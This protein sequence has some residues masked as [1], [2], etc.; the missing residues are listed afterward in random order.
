M[1]AWIHTFIM[2]SKMIFSY[3]FLSLHIKYPSPF[4]HHT[5]LGLCGFSGCCINGLSNLAEMAT[6]DCPDVH[7]CPVLLSMGESQPGH[8][9]MQ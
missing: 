1:P 8:I 6:Y 5:L 2:V 3:F 4:E 9:F 7:I